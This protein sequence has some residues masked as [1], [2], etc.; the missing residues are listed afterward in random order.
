MHPEPARAR[1]IGFGAS[2]L[3]IEVFAYVMTRDSA[4]FLLS[5]IHICFVLPAEDVDRLR[6]VAGQLLRASPE[7]ESLVREF[8]G[9]PVK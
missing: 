7:Y 4:E 6:Q 8:G 3:D 2:S 5:L 1:F 9:N